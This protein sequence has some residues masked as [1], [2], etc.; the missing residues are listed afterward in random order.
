MRVPDFLVGSCFE[1]LWDLYEGSVRLRTLKVL[2]R[3]QW[4][5]P[6]MVRARQNEALA[7]LARH[8]ATTCEFHRRRFAEAGI[9]PQGVRTIADLAGLPILTKADIRERQ[10]DLF[11]SAYA[12]ADLVRAKTGGSTGVSLEVWCDRP[13]IEKRAAAAL[14]ADEWSGWRFGQSMAAIW[15]NPPKAMTLRNRLRCWLKDRV[16]YLDTMHIDEAAID[17]FLAEW[18][19]ERPGMLFGH[20]HSLYI[21]AENLQARGL[22]LDPTGIVAT[23]MMLIENE[24]R[25]I[26]EVCGIPVTNRYGCE[27]VSLIACE[28]EQHRGLHLNAEHVIVEFLRDDG[29][30][31]APGE[32]G[33]IIVTELVNYGQP[34][35]RYEV[36]DRGVPGDRLCPCGRGAPMMESLT[37]RVADF[38]V[39]EGGHRVAGISIIENT[40]T[41]F[42]GIRQLQIV[43][44]ARD[45]LLV[46]IVPGPEFDGEVQRQL[47]TMLRQILGAGL[48]IDLVEV[49]RIMP[50]RNGKYRFTICRI[51]P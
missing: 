30:P 4:D 9:D 43:Q 29:S 45:H 14:L 19:R 51:T 7:Q 1:P 10:E 35:I 15:G 23:S 11:S 3:R 46:N 17:R 18:Q 22:R 34:L 49:P 48:A 37:G 38:L 31:C 5:R 40:L 28:C 36:G 41:K 21:L 42:P 6:E 20:A 50:E 33:R 16:I 25:V 2:R 8:A 39:A 24:R 26:E 12:Q 44:D 47:T 32:D 27:E 13:G